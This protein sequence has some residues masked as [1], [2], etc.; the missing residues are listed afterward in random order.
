MQGLGP[1][2]SILR[3]DKEEAVP[4][5]PE[6]DCTGPVHTCATWIQCSTNLALS[7]AVLLGSL[8]QVVVM[9]LTTLWKWSTVAWMVGARCSFPGLILLHQEE[10]RH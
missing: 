2:T 10:P 8:R 6:R 3:T 7:R 1:H 9:K 5:A 4:K